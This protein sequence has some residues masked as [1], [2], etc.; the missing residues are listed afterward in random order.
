MTDAER[1]L[2]SILRGRQI[3]GLKFCRQHPFEDYILDFV[4]LEVKL[5][6]EVDGG[7]H[8]KRLAED[9]IRTKALEH[10]GFRVLRFWNH[11]VLLQ[12]EAVAEQILQAVSQK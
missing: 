5:V 4:C 12:F 11:D 10:A 1:N 8:Q 2:W 9:S 7:Q 3:D 6:V